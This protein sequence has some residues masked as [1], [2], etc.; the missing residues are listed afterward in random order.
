MKK[1]ETVCLFSLY[2]S[3]LETILRN[4]QIL[5]CSL[6]PPAPAP[7]CYTV[8]VINIFVKVWGNSLKDKILSGQS[9]R[10]RPWHSCTIHPA[11]TWLFYPKSTRINW[12]YFSSIGGPEGL[13]RKCLR[14]GT[15]VWRPD[16]NPR[17]LGWVIRVLKVYDVRVNWLDKMHLFHRRIYWSFTLKIAYW[18]YTNMT[19]ILWGSLDSKHFFLLKKR[20][21]QT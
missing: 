16:A 10:I 21:G 5:M 2:S 15:K 12:Q 19:I 18:F 3:F 11:S 20:L 7:T 8:I 17:G 4:S 6:Q 13:F 9:P 1:I 14:D